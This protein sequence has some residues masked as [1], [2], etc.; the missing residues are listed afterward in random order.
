MFYSKR[1]FVASIIGFLCGIFCFVVGKYILGLPLEMSNL[2][3]ILLNR[4]IMG[5]SIG[6]SILQIGWV[7]HGAL[8]GTIIGTIFAYSDA[9]L[10]FPAYIVVLVI[11]VNPIFGI[12]IEYFTT[13][14]F[15][16]PVK[17]NTN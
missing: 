1:V 17:K 11:I 7:K 16:A 4:T 10:G 2:G 12:I 3:F 14:V 9:M 8:I 15:N 13:V 5:V 6:I